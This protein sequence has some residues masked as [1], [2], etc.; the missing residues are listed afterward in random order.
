[1]SHLNYYKCLPRVRNAEPVA[2]PNSSHLLP[3]LPIAPVRL[4]FSCVTQV[5]AHGSGA[6]CRID[7]GRKSCK[8]SFEASHLVMTSASMAYLSPAAQTFAR[9]LAALEDVRAAKNPEPGSMPHSAL[10]ITALARVSMG[11]ARQLL[12][13]GVIHLAFRFG[14]L[15]VE[16]GVAMSVGRSL[17]R[18]P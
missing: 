3:R 15:V 7:R 2:E 6:R 5:P 4:C 1:M 13:A 9:E 8:N 10:P 11:T 16:N 17:T 18:C 14:P 12:P